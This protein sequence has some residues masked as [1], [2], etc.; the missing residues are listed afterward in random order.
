M[1]VRSIDTIGMNIIEAVVCSDRGPSDCDDAAQLIDYYLS[2]GMNPIIRKACIQVSGDVIF[3]HFDHLS[4]I[5]MHL[6]L[7]WI[8]SSVMRC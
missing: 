3:Q 2:L 6:P 4:I 8:S 7:M 5:A 1:L